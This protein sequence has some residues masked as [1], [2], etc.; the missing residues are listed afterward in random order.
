MNS[1]NKKF[2]GRIYAVHFG[3]QT[4]VTRQFVHDLLPFLNDHLNLVLI[5]NSPQTDLSFAESGLIQVINC[6]KNEG[7]F[8]A[9][10]YALT[11]VPIDGLDYMIISN[12]DIRIV[13]PDFFSLIEEKLSE[14]DIIAPS[15]LTPDGID[16][17]PHREH[18]PS[19]F[20]KLYHRIYFSCYPIAWLIEQ[21]YVV[22][23]KAANSIKTPG[24]ERAIFSPHGAFIIL[25]SSFFKKGG[26]ID[27]GCFLYAEEDSL[28][29]MAHLKGMKIGYI[30]R[31]KVLHFESQTTGKVISRKKYRF[32]KEAYLYIRQHYPFIYN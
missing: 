10:R 9:I 20:R 18:I 14:W 2:Q 16:Q 12:N 7:Y 21:S 26:S 31:L 29:A 6:T 28:A 13:S 17:N 24:S 3:D 25:N 4:E 32:K 8:G 1:P 5:N 30:P 22:R 11:Q 15:T 27:S 19:R 23:K